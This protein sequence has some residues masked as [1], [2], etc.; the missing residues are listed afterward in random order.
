MLIKPWETVSMIY[1]KF[2]YGMSGRQGTTLEV[3]FF[4]PSCGFWIILRCQGL[5]DKMLNY[6][7]ILRSFCGVLFGRW[8]S[9]YV[10]Q[11]GFELEILLPQYWVLSWITFH[12]SLNDDHPFVKQI[13]NHVNSYFKWQCNFK[14]ISIGYG[15]VA[16]SHHS[17]GHATKS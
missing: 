1:V 6:W 14:P 11:Y 15:S 4:F 10:V 5:G 7:F 9:Y 17:L 16:W 12:L 8:G 13:N 2:I 3:S